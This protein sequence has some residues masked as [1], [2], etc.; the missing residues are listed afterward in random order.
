V[1]G[2]DGAPNGSPVANGE[3]RSAVGGRRRR[4]EGEVDDVLARLLGR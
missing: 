3:A 1:N 4:A 2:S